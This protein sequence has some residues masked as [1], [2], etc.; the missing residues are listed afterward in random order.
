M[1]RAIAGAGLLCITHIGAYALGAALHESRSPALVRAAL[2]ER[3]VTVAG[4]MA[5]AA[6]DARRWHG[7][8]ERASDWSRVVTE[9]Q[10]ALTR[11]TSQLGVLH[12]RAS[13]AEQQRASALN[14]LQHAHAIARARA[15]EIYAHDCKAWA[16]QPV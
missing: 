3:G 11:C 15:E 8:W 4:A 2:G 10:G 6:H 9:M 13:A 5:L 14:A 1:W 16:D 7:E 12:T